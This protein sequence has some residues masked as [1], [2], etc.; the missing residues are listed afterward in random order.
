VTPTPAAGL[1]TGAKVG[2]SLSIIIVALVLV[3]LV[4]IFVVRKK[5]STVPPS[6]LVVTQVENKN[7]NAPPTHPQELHGTTSI[8]TSYGQH[9]VAELG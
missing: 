1:S 6:T 9:H 2:I 7:V 5:K 3:A 8:H 4:Y